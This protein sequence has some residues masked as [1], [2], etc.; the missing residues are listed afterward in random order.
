MIKLEQGRD[1]KEGVIED[2]KKTGGAQQ[3]FTVDA[4]GKGYVQEIALPW[5]L[6]TRD[7]QPLKAG[8]AFT[9]TIEPNFTIGA[10]GRLSVK[11]IFKPGITPDRVFTFMASRCWGTATLEARRNVVPQPVRLADAR[12][13]PVHSAGDTLVV[14]W[15]GLR[16]TE[17][18]PGFI[19][20]PFNMPF[21]GYLSLNLRNAD[22]QVVRQLLNCA[23]FTQGQHE[24]KWDGLTTWSW[25]RPGEPVPPGQY[26]WSAL[27][28]TGIGLKL[29]GWACNGGQSPWDSPDG[30]GNW[31]GDHGVPVAVTADDRQVYLGWNGAEAGKSVLACDLQ[32]RVQWSNNRGGMAGVKALAA[33]AGV[34]YVLGGNVGKDAEGANLY[35]LSAKDGSYL[36]WDG[37]DSADLKIK[38]LWPADATTK[39]EK[40]DEMFFNHG[41]LWLAFHV[42]EVLME[43][44]PASGK[45]VQNHQLPYGKNAKN[46]PQLLIKDGRVYLGKR[47]PENQVVVKQG[48]ETVLT[49][50]RAGG[51]QLL[52]LW[53]SDGMR[54]LNRMDI[55]AE[56]KLWV[57]EADGTPKRISVWDT[58]TGQLV[59]EF[60]GPSS[61]GALGGAICPADPN[62]MVG[63]GCEWRLDPQTGRAHCTTVITRNGMENSRFAR[64]ANGRLYLAV[65]GN[66]AFNTGPLNIYERLGDADYRLRTTIFY[67]DKAG[68]EFGTTGHGQTGK[69]AH[70]MVWSDA[71]GDGQRQ[72][73]E[74]SGTDGEL[75]FSSWYMNL[76]PD[77]TL[78]SGAN[79]FKAI[80]FTACGAPKYDLAKPVKMPISGMGS[81]DGRFVLRGGAY[82]E[83]HTLFTCADIASGQIRW[84]YPDN[85]NGVHGSHNACPPTVGM[86][87]GSY[88]PCGTAQLP[89]PIGNV[90]VIPTNVGEWH[91]LTEDGFYLTRLFEGDPMKVKWP[92]RAVPGADMTHCPPGMGGEDFGGSI[93]QGP[94]GKLYVQAG[95]TA[96][97]NLEVTGLETVRKL[98]QSD[99]GSSRERSITVTAADVEK[100]RTLREQQL[101]TTV[102][103]RRLAVKKLTPKFTGN[104]DRDFQGA[105]IV[106]YQKTDD[107]A[108]RSVTAWDNQ[109]LYLAWDVHDQTPW[110]NGAQTPENLYLS[111]DTVDFQLGTDAHADPKRDQAGLG[112]LRLSIGNFKGAPTAVFYRPIAK[113]KHPKT[114]SSGVV[115]EYIVDRVEVLSEVQIKVTL[116]RN[117]YLVEAAVPLSLLDVQPTDGMRLHGD[118]GVTY[119]DPAGQRT[120]LRN[121]WN[122]QHT[123]IVDDAVFELKLEPQH[124]GELTFQ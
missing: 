31:G 22:G 44:D 107:T 50:G 73:E 48:Q 112:D 121:Y 11:D 36:K 90:W 27:V 97:W 86:I 87:R 16:Q 54:F 84:T 39:P 14:D 2:A 120:R 78:Y 56:G 111:G 110:I 99:A 10:K 67:T 45:L 47:D 70:T 89:K 94:D 123:G 7:G 26:T 124:W 66:W 74:I 30:K 61:Y 24:V 37:T 75:R 69:A 46:S 21:D 102:G 58:Q 92:E 77:L 23:F 103:T 79:Q 32:G 63:Q 29:R 72:P 41:K 18:L 15:S 33:D 8:D 76:A 40:A 57:A 85:F 106:R 96:F 49:I 101:Q 95:K 68:E 65:A 71:N 100:A 53:Q 113:I 118:F 88:G 80:G 34:L 9:L 104:L 19:P 81:A 119:G 60:F 42:A 109:T 25:T 13:F 62:V 59:K 52:G 51:R 64:G 6:L 43:L 114:F 4:N 116:R 115:K 82:G 35:K 1:F 17:E 55:D 5:K 91:L 3:A 38:N 93:A 108:V 20:I 28:H 83:T 105:E 117:S 98:A 122:N 12:E